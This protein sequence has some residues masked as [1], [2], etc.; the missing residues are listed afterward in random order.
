MKIKKCPLNSG[1]LL[2]N[3]SI[4]SYLFFLFKID[5]E[6]ASMNQVFY[7]IY[8]LPSQWLFRRYI[9]EIV[10]RKIEKLRPLH[11]SLFGKCISEKLKCHFFI[12]Q[13][14][15]WSKSIAN[16][17]QNPCKKSFNS[18]R[19]SLKHSSIVFHQFK[20]NKRNWNLR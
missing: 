5:Y 10:K 4:E 9:F 1:A 15:A 20:R 18:Q 12:K 19:F 8:N 3:N 17:S 14:I 13:N 11:V 16:L 7:F 6:D 2:K